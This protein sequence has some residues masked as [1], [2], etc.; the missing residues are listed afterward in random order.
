[1][2]AGLGSYAYRYA[3][4]PSLT[5]DQMDLSKMLEFCNTHEIGAIQVCENLP[6]HKLSEAELDNGR[7]LAEKYSI[8]VELGT[9]GYS[10][11]HIQKYITIS[12]LF[13]ATILRTVLNASSD[14]DIGGILKELKHIV[15]YLEKAGITLA[16][17][18]HFDL[19]P[20]GLSRLIDD[21]GHPLVK[22]CI[23]PLNS[24]SQLWG[25]NETFE[26]LKKH[27]VTAHIKDVQI[28]RKGTSFT[29]SGCKLGKGVAGTENYIKNIYQINR[30]CNIFFEQWLDPLES[31]E[32]TIREE[33]IRVTDGLSYINNII[34]GLKY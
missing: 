3:M 1:M 22:V 26:K 28:T 15:P 4:Q 33:E 14:K 12:T 23:D 17:E 6:L 18:N 8:E 30:E 34:A 10:F 31:Q 32:A 9:V 21:I 13:N 11:D 2:K 29:I 19:S 7:L 5:G 24:I 20:E 25:I 16:I 27:I